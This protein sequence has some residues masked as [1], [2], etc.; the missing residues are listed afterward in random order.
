MIGQNQKKKEKNLGSKVFLG[1]ALLVSLLFHLFFLREL[2]RYTPPESSSSL[3]KDYVKL[4]FLPEKTPLTKTQKKLDEKKVEDESEK[5]I[6]ET[7]LKPTERPLDFDYLGQTDHKA[8][9]ITKLKN[10]P[11]SK[12]ADPGLQ[13]GIK[14]KVK[15]KEISP[16]KGQDLKPNEQKQEM[17]KKGPVGENNTETELADKN[18][19]DVL[20]KKGLGDLKTRS[21]NG[22]NGYEN[23][24][25]RSLKKIANNE[26]QA[27]YVDYLNDKID[28]GDTI[29]LN[30][31]EYRFIGYF[32]GLRKAIELVWVYPSEAAHRGVYG[33]VNLKFIIEANGKVSKIQVVESSGHTILDQA[34]VEA[35]RLAS[36]FAPLPKGFQK[37]KLIV[38]GN[39]T[40]VLN[41][42]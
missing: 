37:D 24:L 40:Y 33:Q 11:D 3:P 18:T 38:K 6:V 22:K 31:H 23:L 36:P 21:A 42:F 9:K 7:P 27:G 35:V 4:K 26:M 12:A 30:T 16:E 20:I 19:P 15:E 8:Q 13:K 10:R 39:F 29:D 17:T 32:T 1:I 28:E 5:K 25:E 2:G 34:I 41:S 14:E